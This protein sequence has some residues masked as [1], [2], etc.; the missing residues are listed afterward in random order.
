MTPRSASKRTH[1]S[2]LLLLNPS[3]SAGP[4]RSI[5]LKRDHLQQALVN[6]C[7]N[8]CD[9][10]QLCVMDVALPGEQ[11]TSCLQAMR[12]RSP[13]LPAVLVNAPLDAEVMDRHTMFLLKPFR[14]TEQPDAACQLPSSRQ[15]TDRADDRPPLSGDILTHPDHSKAGIRVHHLLR[16]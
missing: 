5:S 3:C 16:L 2:T 6:L 15:K 9:A 10:A 12:R 14:A 4:R 11:G 1:R 7:N 13:R 8:A